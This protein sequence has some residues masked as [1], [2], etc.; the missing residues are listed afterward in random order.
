MNKQKV[1]VIVHATNEAACLRLK[2]SLEKIVLP[3]KFSVNVRF[4]TGDKK[5]SA[6][7]D[8]M[9]ASDA[10]YKIYLD[11]Q[12]VVTNE[13]F[14]SELLEIF[15]DNKIGAVGTSGALELSTNGVSLRSVKRGGKN[16]V[17]YP[18]AKISGSN[19]FGAAEVID[20]FFFAT[21]YDLPWRHDLFTDNFF[22]GQA[23]CVEFRRAGYK[24]FIPQQDKPWISFCG[25]KISLDESSRQKFLDEYSKD[26]FPL[27]SVII[28]TYNRPKYFREALD[29]ALNQTYRNIEIFV[30]DNSSEDDTEILMQDYLARDK[31][32]K[33][34]RHKEFDADGNWNFAR[35]YNNPAAEYV[36][37]LMDDDLF[38][39]TKIE[40][41][42]EVYRDNPDVT[43]VTSARDFIDANGKV[44]SNT[45]NIFGKDVKMSGDAAGRMLFTYLQYIGEPTTVL[46]RKK[47]LRNNDLC[48]NADETGFF[49]LVDMS[50][51]LHLL[52][53]GSMVRLIECLSA[54]R[55]HEQQM[56]YSKKIYKRATYDYAKLL[57]QAWDGKFFVNKER[58]FRICASG[59]LWEACKRLNTVYK[60]GPYDEDVKFLEKTIAALSQ[61]LL[62]DCNLDL[63]FG[64]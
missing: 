12:V 61:S 17:G 41:M 24:I 53:Q 10:K 60:V 21:Q 16:F 20:G 62:N 11:E 14:L 30:S 57:K 27:V 64:K 3:K 25:T 29:S 47:F 39:P 32:I 50:T 51:W 63:D 7:N 26:L 59:L 28:P 23:Q 2:T 55:T 43:L 19:N 44:V 38:Y 18:T 34:F 31:R 22:G 54:L 49:S 13:N 35:S 8:A 48:H 52:E 36:N 56:T 58:D 40:K 37:W 46:I 15:S 9:R 5:F 4:V 42:V 33:Y 45:K 1:E 6:Y